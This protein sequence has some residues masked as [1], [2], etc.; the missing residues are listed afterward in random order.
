MCYYPC[1]TDAESVLSR[2][3][4]SQPEQGENL[5]YVAI[6]PGCIIIIKPIIE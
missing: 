6:S 5:Y 4:N 1:I 3:G 2:L